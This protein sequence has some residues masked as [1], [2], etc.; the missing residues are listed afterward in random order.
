L[1]GQR[2][3]D[4]ISR[5]K[6]ENDRRGQARAARRVN[7]SALE[8]GDGEVPA[9]TVDVDAHMSREQWGQNHEQQ[10]A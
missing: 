4:E 6:Q 10:S 2:C 5:N 7:S 8:R 3:L 9:A 1:I